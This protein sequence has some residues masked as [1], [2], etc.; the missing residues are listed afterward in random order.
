MHNFV[1]EGRRT[2]YL[3]NDAYGEGDFIAPLV[4]SD[5]V[6]LNHLAIPLVCGAARWVAKPA[7]T[8]DT[9]L[10]SRKCV[11]RTRRQRTPYLEVSRTALRATVGIID[12]TNN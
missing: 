5:A 4:H 12:K 10:G 6:Y 9:F 8:V 2:A 11:C 7:L 3:V 1:S